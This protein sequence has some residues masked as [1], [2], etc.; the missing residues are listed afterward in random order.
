MR[1]SECNTP[2]L[3]RYGYL[4]QRKSNRCLGCLVAASP[5][6]PL[7]PVCLAMR[8]FV[9]VALSSQPWESGVECDGAFAQRTGAKSAKCQWFIRLIT[10]RRTTQTHWP[11]VVCAAYYPWL[12]FGD[13]IF[14]SN[15][16]LPFLPCTWDLRADP[17]PRLDEN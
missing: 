6:N 15:P 1:I 8:R 12:Q 3:E 5:G 16:L 7:A 4:S 11:L 9:S 2:L 13:G 10:C 17:L 14:R